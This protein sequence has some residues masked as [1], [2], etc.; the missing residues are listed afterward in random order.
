MRTRPNLLI[1][2]ADQLSAPVLRVYGGSVARTPHIDALADRGVVFDSFYCN[3]PLCAPSRFSF[4]AGQLP[5]KIGAYDN[6][7]EFGATTP[8]FAHYL[9]LAGYLTILSGKMHFCGPDQLHGFEERLTT[10][11]Y[12]A[13]F[14]WTPD[15]TRPD[16]RPAWYHT[17]DSV[18]QAGPC[19]RTCQLDFDDEVVG[20]ARQKLFDLAR[21][22]DRRPFCMVVSMTHPHDPYAVPDEYWN[23]YR[24]EEIPPPRVPDLSGREDPHSR[25][26]RHVIGLGLAQ[27]TEEEVLRARRAYYGAVSYV[28]DQIGVLLAALRQAHLADD[29][30][31]IVLADHGDMLGERGLWY[32]MSFFEPACR[33]PL[34]MHAPGRFAPRRV[35][36]LASLVDLLPTLVALATGDR[37]PAYAAPIDG[38]SLLPALEGGLGA[39]EVTGEYLAEGAIA[40]IVMIRRSRHKFVHSTADPDQLYDLVADPDERA[41]I[42]AHA[43]H[44]ALVAGFRE[45]VARRWDLNGV[46]AAVLASQ[47]RRHLVYAALREGRYRPWDFQPLR[48]AARSYIRNDQELNDLE[49]MGRFPPLA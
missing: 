27:P 47:Q 29:T 30:V 5:S 3:S 21:S 7:A 19:V 24:E 4:M 6:A 40:P 39:G 20:A 11:I 23:R 25:R 41:N 26:L 43:E 17:M 10:D 22:D 9:R 38:S 34:I 2:M 45:E 13:D 32:K 49:R 42:A 12:P 33:I 36:E 1:L 16:D 35:A 37:A 28:D 46:H 31:T 8:T 18:T 44:A 14:G 15:W 48:D